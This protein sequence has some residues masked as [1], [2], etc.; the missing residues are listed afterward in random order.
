MAKVTRKKV[1][2]SNNRCACAFFPC[3]L[4]KSGSHDWNIP[5][6]DQVKRERR[7][8]AYLLPLACSMIPPKSMHPK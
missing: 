2:A 7:L 8:G 4:I 5:K 3:C 1:M 6:E